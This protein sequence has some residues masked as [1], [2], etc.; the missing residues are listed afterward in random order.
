MNKAVFLD[1]DGTI[2]KDFGYVYRLDQLE[3]LPMVACGIAL[4]REKG[5]LIIVVTNQSGIARGYYT[6]EQAITFNQKLNDKLKEEGAQ[7]DAVYMCPHGVD[8]NCDCRKP[9]IGLFQKAVND[10]NID[11]SN[12]Y[13]FGDRVRDISGMLAK[14]C[15][16][17]LIGREEKGYLSYQNLYEAAK[18]FV[19]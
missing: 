2:N 1:R 18:Y 19:D 7:F 4:M 3:I 11:L 10:F 6:I 9:N 8:D 5:Y 13:C 14:G 16:C 17:A 12:S 15:H